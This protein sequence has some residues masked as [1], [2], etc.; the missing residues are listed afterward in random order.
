M[1]IKK[2]IAEKILGRALSTGGDFAEIFAEDSLK[3]SIRMIDDKIDTAISGRLY[4]AGIRIYRGVKSVYATT[5]DLTEKGLLECAERAAAVIGSLKADIQVNLTEKK[6]P[7]VHPV[8]LLPGSVDAKEKAALI[9]AAYW[10][11]KNYS[12]EIVQA[13][14][15]LLERVQNVC[16]A[17][18]EGLFTEDRRVYTRFGNLALA[19]DGVENQ[20]GWEAPGR[21]RGYEVFRDE[22]DVEE[23]AKTAAKTAVTMLHAGNCPAGRMTVAI[24]NAFGGAIFHEACGHL[25]EAT[26][27]AKGSSPFA[28]KIGQKIAN[29]KVTAIDDGTIPNAWGSINIDDEG[30]PARRNVLIKDG[31]LQGYLVDRLNGRIMGMESTGS[32]RRESYQYAPTSRMTNTYIDKGPDKSEDIIKSI[33]YG[34]YAR[35]MGGGSVSPA[36][37][38]FNFAVAEGYIVRKGE[39][40]EAVRGAS[41]IGKG[42]E[43]IMNIDMVGQNLAHGAGM[44]GSISG[45]VPTNVGQPLIRVSEITVGGR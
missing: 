31:V 6:Y 26:S 24:E 18:S 20:S 19:S 7:D 5:N 3:N 41:L 12:P 39:I 21:M 42:A 15:S 34:L 44:C 37:G 14:T 17:N 35:K 33:E 40:C 1:L 9:K 29:E 13:Q 28:G 30:S 16:I 45:S 10:A 8:A 23:Y 2:A 22:I 32:G 36:T 38:E 43:I 4:G 11:L 25:L 27:V